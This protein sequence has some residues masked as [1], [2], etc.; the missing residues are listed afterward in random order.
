MSDSGP[1]NPKLPTLWHGGDYNPDQWPEDIRRED[2]RLMQLAHVNVASVAIFAWSQLEPRPGEYDWS[3]LDET[4]DRLPR[5]GVSIALATPSAAHPRWLSA[6]HPDVQAADNTGRRLPHGARQR[7]CPSSPIYREHVAR[8]DRAM[9]ERYGSHPALVLWHVSNEYVNV[10][11][12]DL[13]AQNFRRWLHHRY[14]TLETLNEQYWSTFWSHRFGDWSEIIP[15]YAT[16]GRILNALVLDWRRFQS[17]QVCD[18]F[19]HEVGVL[20]EAT[21]GVPVTTNLMG[22][23]AGLDYAKFADVCDVVSWDSYPRVGGD[24]AHVACAHAMM[25]GLKAG[26]PWLLIEQTPSTTNWMEHYALKPPGLMRLWSWQAIG[27]GS[28]SA[29]YFQWRRSR[30]GIEKLH[31]AV[32][33]HVGN[34]K[35]RVFHEVA[36][37]GGEMARI[38]PRVVGTRAAR[39]RVGVLWDQ[40]NRWALE[41]SDG[42]GHE[43]R[44]VE[45]AVKH[46]RA[47]WNSR[48]PVDV[49][50]MDA[51]WSGY[52][53]LIAPMMYV[54]KSGKFP[55]QAPPEE[56]APRANEAEKIE[57]WVSGGGT[58][59][60]TYLTGIANESDLVYEGGYPGPLRKVLGIW[61]EE[62][63]MP[64][65]AVARNKMAMLKGA[66]A[67]AKSAYACERVFDLIHAET[68]KVLARY[69]SN[70]YKGRPCLTVNAFGQGLAYYIATDAA[71]AFLVDF[72]RAIA[73]RKGI[74]PAVKP[75]ADVE[76]LEREGPGRR[77]V[78]VL[79]HAAKPRQVALGKLKG[80]E[81]LSDKAVKGTL[82][83]EPYG[84]RVIECA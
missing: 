77:L 74:E 34:E 82:K 15:P 63:D 67:G 60:A 47:V 41:F 43:R 21:P 62:L 25:R 23:Y 32:V 42:P 65:P 18:F 83:L 49:V 54:V 66:F 75:V 30:G 44:V 12:C 68:A 71:D 61:A 16:C 29:M 51:D 46:Y 64:D 1:V 6:M 76:V 28:D 79:N 69:A 4:F 7:F 37:L 73:A 78:F 72:Y 48:I 14:G 9:A 20:A 52:D 80:K 17:H 84:V 58:F 56:I 8:I 3:W 13:C 38:G 10:C 19:K 35:P 5:A 11:W 59:V 50:R 22:F 40:E 36:A 24:P 31:G 39:A 57:N 70:W 2:A 26:R 81:L 33:E 55:L 27:H 45:T 53:V